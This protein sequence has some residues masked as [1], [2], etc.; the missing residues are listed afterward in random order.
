MGSLLKF[1]FFAFLILL[2]SAFALPL[3]WLVIKLVVW[4]FGGM[5]SGL[6]LG[7]TGG[8]VLCLLFIVACVVFVIWC[9][10]S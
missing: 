3:L 6:C 5:F 4:L 8:D 1:V 9:I 10:A 2:I 7:I